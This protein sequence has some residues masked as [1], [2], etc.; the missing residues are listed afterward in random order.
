MFFKSKTSRDDSA[1]TS[2]SPSPKHSLRSFNYLMQDAGIM[3]G[4]HLKECPA[5]IYWDGSSVRRE[6]RGLPECHEACLW[7]LQRHT[8]PCLFLWLSVS[9]PVCLSSIHSSSQDFSPF[10][11]GYEG[12][13]ETA[14]H[15]QGWQVNLGGGNHNSNFT[16]QHLLFTGLYPRELLY[17]VISSCECG[18]EQS[19]AFGEKTRNVTVWHCPVKEDFNQRSKKQKRRNLTLWK[20]TLVDARLEGWMRNGRVKSKRRERGWLS[21]IKEKQKSISITWRDKTPDYVQW[22]GLNPYSLLCLRSHSIAE[23]TRKAFVHDK[24]IFD[25]RFVDIWHNCWLF[26]NP[27]GKHTP[28]PQSQVWREKGHGNMTTFISL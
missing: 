6:E 7:F 27:T 12:P 21:S 17:C 11:R 3:L 4:R 2:L 14:S 8:Y 28:S 20:F 25:I 9:L 1:R 19:W 10:S 23:A 16:F 5:F 26:P 13:K 18:T 22:R 24:W 15:G